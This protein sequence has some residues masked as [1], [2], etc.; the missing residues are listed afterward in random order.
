VKKFDLRKAFIIILYMLV[1]AFLIVM[2][3]SRSS[4]LYPF[5]NWDDANCFFTVGKS[6]FNGIVL[7]KD[8]YE[9]KGPLLYFIYGVAYLMS[10]TTFIGAFF[11]EVIFA[12]VYMLALYKIARLY[13]DFIPSL[14]ISALSVAISFST[15]AFYFGGSAEELCFPLAAIPTYFLLKC[16]KNGDG[17][18]AW[19]KM[20]ISGFCAGCI[21]L[22][23]FT[24]LSFAIMF[25][26]FVI[27]EFIRRKNYS[28]IWKAA[29][30]YL[31]GAM[32]AFIPWII[33][34]GVNGAFKDFYTVYIYNNIFIY[35]SSNGSLGFLTSTRI[36]IRNYFINFANV[37]VHNPLF[38]S[39]VI[40]GFFWIIFGNNIKRFSMDKVFVPLTGVTVFLCSFIGGYGYYYALPISLFTVFG[41]IAVYCVVS[42]GIIYYVTRLK[43]EKEA[44]KVSASASQNISDGEASSFS[45][46]SESGG[47]KT[48]ERGKNFKNIVAAAVCA[49]AT[50]ISVG[51]CFLL[52]MNVSYIG[53]DRNGLF[54]YKFA[55]IIKEKGGGTILNYGALDF[56][57]YTVT[58]TLPTCKYFCGLNIGLSELKE[59]QDEF[60]SEG[61]VDFVVCE[62]DYP[63]NIDSHYTLIATDQKRFDDSENIIYLF[64][65]NN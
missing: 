40:V 61:K 45:S 2:V 1:A 21:F 25:V 19:Y 26:L 55:D 28:G 64:Q 37:F 14:A 9:Q 33:Y 24:I 5:N 23:K 53:Y 42:K 36:R 63:E 50:V 22:I 57:L 34:F 30:L 10:H 32:I 16:F 38:C 35:G 27:I 39:L 46:V 6:M 3:C 43:R 4:F 17:K 29:L 59:V 31:G 18:I 60:I 54:M 7:Y 12:C 51:G 47:E 48:K 11:I 44:E 62:V 49:A 58:D 65:K 15:Y 41:L 52:S 56:G 13:V 8:I 20:L